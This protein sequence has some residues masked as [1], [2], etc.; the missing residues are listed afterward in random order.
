MRATQLTYEC[1]GQ[2]REPRVDEGQ[3]VGVFSN[4][5]VG[6]AVVLHGKGKD[7]GFRPAPS[8][9][10]S[11]THF[12]GWAPNAYAKLGHPRTSHKASDN[13]G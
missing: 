12:S 7:G 6:R 1:C 13:E 5:N 3:G 10:C 9:S 11:T 2:E 8:H 4:E